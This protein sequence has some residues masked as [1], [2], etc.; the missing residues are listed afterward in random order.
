MKITGV[1]SIAYGYESARPMGDANFP[2]G[3]TRWSALAVFID[4]DEGLTGVCIGS[5]AARAQ[6]DTLGRLLLGEDPRGVR[7]LWRRMTDYAFKVGTG[8]IMG[9]AIA[10]LDTAL[11]DLKAKAAGEPL[12]RT[13]GATEPRV[14]AYASGIDICLG[15]AELRDYYEGMAALGVNA[16]KLK[17]GVDQESDL[18]RIG[19]MKDALS[20][21]GTRPG[22]AID[23]NE[24]WYP[25]QAIR[26][27]TEIEERYDLLWVEEPARRW[28]YR[29]L[30]QVS[31]AIR[32]AVASGENLAGLGEFLPLAE[33]GAAD[34][35][36]IGSPFVGGALGITGGMQA[37]DL[38]AAF[39]LPVTMVFCPGNYM[40]HLGAAL[41]NC[42]MAEVVG[43]IEPCFSFDNRIEDGWIVL[44]DSPGL[45]IE[46][47]AEKL[48]ALALDPAEASGALMPGRGNHGG[49]W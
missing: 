22:L 47:D 21:S 1:R 15:D 18:R 34:I 25:K 6:V 45:G 5:A 49:D 16:G 9:L 35:L 29:G 28:D 31:R 4:T 26:R 11:W 42:L 44:G 23:V 14:R 17:A 20:R 7:G 2:E 24:Y 46:F 43:G 38:A 48:Q 27:I 41:P 40:A 30:R 37:A 12:W 10:A 33:R 13:L 32:A 3:R 36:Q 39:E 19:I 8:G